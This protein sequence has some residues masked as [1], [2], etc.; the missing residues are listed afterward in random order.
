METASWVSPRQ[1]VNRLA[2]RVG[3]ALHR[4]GFRRRPGRPACDARDHGPFPGVEAMAQRSS[5][6]HAGDTL[7]GKERREGLGHRRRPDGAGSQRVAHLPERHRHKRYGVV[8]CVSA[9]HKDPELKFADRTEGA[10]TDPLALEIAGG[11]N[12][13]A[14]HQGD[15]EVVGRLLEAERSDEDLA[16]VARARQKR[17]KVAADPGVDRTVAERSGRRRPVREPRHLDL[18]SGGREVAAL[19]CERKGQRKRV[20]HVA[21]PDH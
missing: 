9:V 19:E 2:H 14:P 10:D 6:D 17:L 20:G 5:V 7:A 15:G 4:L 3:K 8:V 18:E 21:H 11:R 16:G 13:V 12:A 1:F